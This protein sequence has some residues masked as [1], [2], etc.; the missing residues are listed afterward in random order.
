[1]TG[2][3]IGVTMGTGGDMATLQKTV[4]P[5]EIG[6]LQRRTGVAYVHEVALDGDENLVQGSRVEIVDGAGEYLAA[7][8][9]A[10]EQTPTGNLYRLTI[11][12]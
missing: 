3:A 4:V 2:R 11:G 8:V 7:T 12:S 6:P 1:M 9:T 5:A 10:V